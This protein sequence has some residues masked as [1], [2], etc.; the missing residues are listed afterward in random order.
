MLQGMPLTYLDEYCRMLWLHTSFRCPAAKLLLPNTVAWNRQC[1]EG[2]GF[3]ISSIE[4]PILAQNRLLFLKRDWTAI[5]GI[6][7]ISKIVKSAGEELKETNMLMTW[8]CWMKPRRN[9]DV[10]WMERG[11]LE[12]TD[13]G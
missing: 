8:F 1:P 5:R 12:Y 11:V 9:K 13:K 2:Y 7:K 10:L 3:N 4:V 6:G